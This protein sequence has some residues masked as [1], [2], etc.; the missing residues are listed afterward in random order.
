MKLPH[1]WKER[2][3]RVLH[4]V[5]SLKQ[6]VP[7]LFQFVQDDI[8]EVDKVVYPWLRRFMIFL[9]LLVVVSILLPIGLELTPELA[10]LNLQIEKA[11]L[12]GFI[13]NIIIRF[14]LT[15]NRLD[16][17]EKR[18]FEVLL[19]ALAIYL[20]TGF[21]SYFLNNDILKSIGIDE[22]E[23]FILNIIKGYLLLFV[24]SKALYNLPELLDRQKN[25]ARLLVYSF[26]LIILTGCAFLMLPGATIDGE[27]LSFM[28]AIFTSTSAV[29]VTGLIVVD[30]ATHFT[31][32]GQIIIMILIQL[33]GIGIVTFATFLFIYISGGLGIPQMNAIKSVLAE[34]NTNLLSTTLK[35]VIGFIFF[36]EGVATI[37][38]YF[39]WDYEFVSNGQR[40]FF[41]LFHS[42]SAFCNAGFSLFTNSLADA[43]NVTNIPVNITTMILII[44]GGLG[45]TSIWE[46]IQRKNPKKQWRKRL[47]VHTRIVLIVTGILIVGGTVLILA[48]EWNNTL[49]DYS[50]GNK[51]LV[52]FFQSVTT[53]TAG[54]NT[55][56]IGEIGVSATLIMLVMMIIGGSPASTAGGIKTTTIAIV[57]RSI[58]MT[59]TGKNRMEIFKRTVPNNIIFQAMSVFFLALI[60]IVISTTLLT[61]TE[62]QAFLDLLFEEVSAFATVGLSRGITA[63]LSNWGKSILVMSMFWGRVGVLTFMVAF[64]KKKENINYQYP[65]ETLMVS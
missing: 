24:G 35:K 60:C 14:I 18:W 3:F 26:L 64:A 21:D 17:L 53:R 15:N 59:V 63:E 31:L 9:T 16:Y 58:A 51:I 39:S 13:A 34:E 61:I 28:D 47:S 25:T 4:E 32:F 12:I 50:W 56:N 42:I 19:S 62:D 54:F 65:E 7:L 2:L 43:H 52:S 49:A 41:S 36:V 37:I 46:I 11:L 44:L 38:Y 29:C 48:L 33:G 6:K 30:T 5:R 20:V 10:R 22:P 40:F 1:H 45:F 57:L 23:T 27:G 8:Y 55:V